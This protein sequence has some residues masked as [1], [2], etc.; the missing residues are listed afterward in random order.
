MLVSIQ[1]PNYFMQLVGNMIRS[2]RRQLAKNIGDVTCK[3]YTT[4]NL[5][6]HDIFMER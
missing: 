6:N 3:H 4:R 2:A 5:Q 1:S